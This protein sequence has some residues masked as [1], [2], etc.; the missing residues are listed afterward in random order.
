MN[1]KDPISEY[2]KEQQLESL[3]EMQ[4]LLQDTQ[5]TYDK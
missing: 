5:Q 3:G 2:S 1:Q 4:F